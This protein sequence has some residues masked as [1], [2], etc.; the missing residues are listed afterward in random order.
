MKIFISCLCEIIKIESNL[1]IIGK[2][3]YLLA[4]TIENNAAIWD[5]F[6]GYIT[7]KINQHSGFIHFV[8]LR[9]LK[10]ENFSVTEKNQNTKLRAITIKIAK[11]IKLAIRW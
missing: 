9:Y 5:I 6:M 8:K 2:V 4:A 1:N 10:F 11:M 3:C 7:W